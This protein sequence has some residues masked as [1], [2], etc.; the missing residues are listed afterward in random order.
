MQLAESDVIEAMRLTEH[1][2]YK[3]DPLIQILSRHQLNN[4]TNRR[5]KRELQKVIRQINI[6]SEKEKE[7]WQEK[8]CV[9][10]S[11][12]TQTKNWRIQILTVA[13]I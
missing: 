2:N 10:N 6:T 11:H 12:V 4:L 7:R 8:G 9:D 5:V 13:T 3:G 1:V